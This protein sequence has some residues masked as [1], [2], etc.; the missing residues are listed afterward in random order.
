MKQKKI[1]KGILDKLNHLGFDHLLGTIISQEYTGNNIDDFLNDEFSYGEYT[2]LLDLQEG[3]ELIMGTVSSNIHVVIVIDYD[4]DGVSSGAIASIF[5]KEYLEYTNC[6]ILNNEREYGNGINTV[7][8][9]QLVKLK[10]QHG[11]LLVITADHGSS[12]DERLEM[13]KKIGCKILVTDHHEVPATGNLKHA[14][15]FIN[16]QRDGGNFNTNISGCTVLFYLLLNTYR[17]YKK[18][19][20][21][22]GIDDELYKLLPFVAV[23]IM[24]DQMDVSDK[25]NRDLYKLGIGHISASLGFWGKLIHSLRIPHHIDSNIIAFN[26]GGLFNTGKRMNSA[27]LVT[28]MMTATH[29]S[30]INR[31]MDNL[32]K[33]NADRKVLQQEL[34]KYAEKQVPGYMKRFKKTIVSVLQEGQGVAGIVANTLADRYSRP[35]FVFTKVGE[36][37]SGSGRSIGGLNLLDVFK[38]FKENHPDK[39]FRGGGHKGAAGCGLEYKDLMLFIESFETVCKN[40]TVDN[41]IYYNL[42]IPIPDVNLE[43]YNRIYSLDPYGMGFRPPVFLS[44]ITISKI[45]LIGKGKEHAIIKTCID[46]ED[47]TLMFFNSATEAKKINTGDVVDVTFSLNKRLQ[48]K[49]ESVSIVI[50]N[51]KVVV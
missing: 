31:Y 12:D 4:N 41:E 40:F 19:N 7:M 13:L 15:V 2:K 36:K 45:F 30:L 39:W 37:L 18:I 42:E 16:P 50:E 35:A 51:L 49:K 26:I 5:F 48:Y 10:N 3:T 6:S 24:T 25:L 11:D 21:K 33:L 20:Y 29:P 47:Y 22:F 1:N 23:T 28:D 27:K 14:D 44:R 43:L 9:D 8:V 32:I 46:G 38:T 17:E 34:T